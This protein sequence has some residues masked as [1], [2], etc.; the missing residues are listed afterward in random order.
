MTAENYQVAARI[1]EPVDGIPAKRVAG[2]YWFDYATASEYSGYARVY[3]ANLVCQGK[4]RST[5]LGRKAH[6]AKGELDE[7][8]VG[9]N[10]A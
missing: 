4:L 6:V 8:L 7:L 5:R 2:R 10:S 9:N 1:I 3:I